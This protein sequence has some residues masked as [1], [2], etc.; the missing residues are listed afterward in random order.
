MKF[1]FIVVL[2]VLSGCQKEPLSAKQ[3]DNKNFMV[4]KLFTNEGC[5]IYRFWD[6]RSH[7]YSDCR[8]SVLGTESCGKNCSRDE[9]IH[10]DR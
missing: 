8:G 7:Y 9:E 5:T 1:L 3:T 6:N 4:E 10:T 2:L